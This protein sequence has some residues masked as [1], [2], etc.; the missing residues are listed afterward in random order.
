MEHERSGRVPITKSILFKGVAIVAVSIGLVCASLFYFIG[1]GDIRLAT[2][3]LQDKGLVVTTLQS[4]DLGEA[5][6]SGNTAQAKDSID[7]ITA[8]GNGNL[9]SVRAPRR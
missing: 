1:K 8:L 4:N 5:I 9:L 7:Q 3:A 6:Q 2:H